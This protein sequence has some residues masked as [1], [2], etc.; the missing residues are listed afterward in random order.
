MNWLLLATH[1]T[2]QHKGKTTLMK[3]H[4]VPRRGQS[5][6]V[7]EANPAYCLFCVTYWSHRVGLGYISLHEMNTDDIKEEW[8]SLSWILQHETMA[9][10]VS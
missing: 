5:L 3:C 9:G 1:P 4:A 10:V 7:W 2:A 8:F 6:G